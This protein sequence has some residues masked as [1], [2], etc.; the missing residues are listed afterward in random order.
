MQTTDDAI[1]K[2]GFHWVNVDEE[3]T[4]GFWFREVGD[5]QMFIEPLMFGQC[6]VSAYINNVLQFKIP[7]KPIDKVNEL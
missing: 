2:A 6:Y 4:Q 5:V 1:R 3:T 7:F